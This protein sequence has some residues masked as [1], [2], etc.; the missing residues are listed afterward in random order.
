MTGVTIAEVMTTSVY[1]GN[2]KSI[3]VDTICLAVGFS[4]M[5]QLL[6]MAGPRDEDNPKRGGQVPICDEYAQTSI[7]RA[8]S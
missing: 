4:P 5:S 1:S 3:D 8:F 7:K 6:K 2:R